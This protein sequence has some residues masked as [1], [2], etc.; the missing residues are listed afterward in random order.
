MSN[1][2]IKKQGFHQN[3]GLQVV[4]EDN[5]EFS[6]MRFIFVITKYPE[7]LDITGCYGKYLK[8]FLVAVSEISGI[9]Q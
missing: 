1:L 5:L 2:F 4:Y 6:P 3:S 8:N 9:I 7:I